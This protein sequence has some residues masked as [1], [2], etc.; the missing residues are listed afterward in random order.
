[1]DEIA[2]RALPGWSVD[3]GK[4]ARAVTKLL[5]LADAAG[6][7][8]A[9]A[10]VLRRWPIALAHTGYPTVRTPGEFVEAWPHF[11]GTGPPQSRKSEPHKEEIERAYQP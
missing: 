6:F 2:K 5:E 10:E 7:A 1:M 11:A 3:W 9:K 8:D 4:Y